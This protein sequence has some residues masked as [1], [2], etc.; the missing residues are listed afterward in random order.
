MKK[1]SEAWTRNIQAAPL[2]NPFRK[3]RQV[4]GP[5]IQSLQGFEHWAVVPSK[6]SVQGGSTKPRHEDVQPFQ[7]CCRHLRARMVDPDIAREGGHVFKPRKPT[8]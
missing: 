2:A 6:H 8:A 7:A 3:A 4:D 1:I 5:A